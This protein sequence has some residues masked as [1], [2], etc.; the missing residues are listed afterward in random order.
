MRKLRFNIASLLSV[1]LV[2]G[3]GFAALRESSDLWESGVFTLTLTAL[4]IS[5]LLAIHRTDSRRSFWIG[6][7]LFGCAYLGLSLVPSIEYRLMT[8]KALGYLRSKLSERSLKINTVQ[9]TGS[10]S[11]APRN[12]VQIPGNNAAGNDGIVVSHEVWL[13]DRTSRRRLNGWSGTTENFVRIGHSLVA[14]MAGWFGGQLSRRLWR[15]SRSPDPT[16]AD[17][18]EG[19]AP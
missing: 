9:H 15:S 18:I 12:Q 4:L 16:T 3:V 17:A 11:L 19:I 8:T 6:F 14:L 13:F 5:V 7:A 1:I 10:W 2:L